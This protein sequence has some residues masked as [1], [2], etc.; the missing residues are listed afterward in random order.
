MSAVV[1]FSPSEGRTDFI[2]AEEAS[3]I[4]SS[5][6][7][8]RPS[9]NQSHFSVGSKHDRPLDPTNATRLTAFYSSS[10]RPLDCCASGRRGLALVTP[11]TM[12]ALETE[13]LLPR[14]PSQHGVSNVEEAPRKKHIGVFSAT[15]IIF[16]RLIG[17]GIFATPAAILGFTGSTGMSLLLWVVGSCYALAGIQVY[18]VWGT[19]FP[20]NGGEKNYLEYLCPHPQRLV[21]CMYAANV[22]LSGMCPWAAGNSLVF[23]EYI[24]KALL[25]A[26]P[27]QAVLQ[28]TA[29]S[30]ITFAFLL[31][32]T[33]YRLGLR[34]QNA[35]GVFKLLTILIVV[36]TGLSAL[37][38]GIPTEAGM[39]QDRWRG[40]ENFKNMWKGTSRSLVSLCTGLYS[41]IWSFSGFSNA[42]Y[43]LSEVRNPARTLRIAGPLAVVVVASL[44]ILANIAYFA[45]ASKSEILSSGRL[46]VSLLMNNI[47][48]E[49][50]ERWVDFGVAL[51]SLGNVL[52]V[53]FSQGRVNQALGK[54][55]ALPFSVIWASDKP[56]NAP[57]G[58]LSLHWFMCVI[59]IL[60]VPSGDAYNF[61]VNVITYPL[62][63]INVTISCGL[64][65]L[66]F[67]ST[68]R[69]TNPLRDP[70]SHQWQ[71]LSRYTLFSA[72]VFGLCSLFLIAVPLMKPPLGAEP[73]QSLPYWTHAVGGWCMFGLGAIW[74]A[75]KVRY[76]RT[77]VE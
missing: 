19:A 34:V 66:Y 30:C 77:L 63:V 24:M 59:V 4:V 14:R 1:L 8:L 27:S 64:L 3:N 26:Q 62:S 68:S 37:R 31:H 33:A 36:A 42:N 58:G 23:G 53:S 5:S 47:W 12:P 21:I 45:G 76:E 32:G 9:L 73:Y 69:P 50:V 48:G 49:Q 17:T 20:R 13:V 57:L 41:V 7:H 43:A 35:L 54:E 44:Y 22:A 46:V 72:V 61:V 52:A 39:P 67:T 51:S 15:F 28:T 29:F 65:Y 25:D 11:G 70:D 6:H 56:F 2:S 74:W 16:N 60:F 18:I 55:G 10:T 38:N 71:N 40:R 75:V